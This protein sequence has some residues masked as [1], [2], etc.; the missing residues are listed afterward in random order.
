MPLKKIAVL[1]SGGGSNLQS[2]IDGIEQGEIAGEIVAVVSN[3]E[4]AFGLERAKQHDIDAVYIGKKNYPDKGER[5]AALIDALASRGVELV[6]L[7]GY[8]QILSESFVKTFQDKIINIHPALIPSFC[9]DGYH[10][11]HV[12][13]AVVE[14]GV[15][16]TGATVH[17]VD[18]G[19]DTGAI[20]YQETVPVYSSDSP[21][22]VQKRVLKVEHQALPYVVKM[23]CEDRVM[24][25]NRKVWIE[26]EQS[27]EACTH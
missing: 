4:K 9:G 19:T 24:K 21:E 5:D 15:K 6:V 20:I 26:E 17:F 13:K 14:Y 22:D 18:E 1:V 8:L 23:F 3:R 25:S 10:G 27:H 11:M 16:V 7:A 12:H 2:I